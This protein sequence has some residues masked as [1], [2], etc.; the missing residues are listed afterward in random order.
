MKKRN[1]N[2]IGHIS[3]SNRP[4]K[5]GI[6]ENIEERIVTGR[7]GRICNELLDDVKETRG[8]CNLKEEA[9]DRSVW[10]TGSEID[11]GRA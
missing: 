10:R 2:W 1:A 9:L 3:R 5:H 7:R 8:Y 4:L 11:N 6:E